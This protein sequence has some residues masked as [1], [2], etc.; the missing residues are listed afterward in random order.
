MS[1][2][3]YGWYVLAT[4][5]SRRMEF[6]V[7]QALHQSE[8]PAL[9]PFEEVIRNKTKRFKERV[10]IP[11][12]PSY[13]FVQLETKK[14]REEYHSLKKFEVRDDNGRII[15]GVVRGL[16]SRRRDEFAPLALTGSDVELVRSLSEIGW[17]TA[18][19]QLSPFQPGAKVKIIDGPFQGHPA[20]IDTV[21][22][23]KVSAMLQLFGSMRVVEFDPNQLAVA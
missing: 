5:A 2:L 9:V 10:R 21:T 23:K 20:K 3:Q 14:I 17:K 1:G 6:K 19:R 8:R 12:Y 11:L 16:L 22:R 15:D 18:M 13:V 4:D 7:A